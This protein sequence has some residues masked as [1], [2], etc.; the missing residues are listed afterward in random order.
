LQIIGGAAHASFLRR[1]LRKAHA[2][3]NPP[4][5]ELSVAM[6]ND[7]TMSDLHLRFM[8]IAGPTDVLTFPLELDTVTPGTILDNRGRKPR[9]AARE[10]REPGLVPPTI[11]IQEIAIGSHP[12]ALT[13]EVVICVPE[14]RRRSREHGTTLQQELLLYALHGM[15]HLCGFD[16]RTD[17]DFKRMHR[18]E[19]QI[20]AR[21]G[22]G[23]VFDSSK[24]RRIARRA[25]SGDD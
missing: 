12:L 25:V 18:T 24:A 10:S 13:G 6:V 5:N 17:R 2:I 22:V 16:D 4:L 14:A 7:R 3:L 19:D 23:P 15:L 20:L 8:N 21:L 11:Q 9:S 1:H